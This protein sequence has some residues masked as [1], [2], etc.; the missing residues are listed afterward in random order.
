MIKKFNEFNKIDNLIN[1][2][3]LL[4]HRRFEPSD[5]MMLLYNI[6]SILDIDNF[7]FVSKIPLSEQANDITGVY[8]KCNDKY[9]DG[10]NTLS[11]E[12]INKKYNING[13][14]KDFLFFDNRD[15]FKSYLKY[16]NINISKD[17]KYIELNEILKKIIEN[18]L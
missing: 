8:Y 11:M 17:N 16:N 7:V 4:I 10:F 15:M 13:N 6:A 2:I 14:Y 9:F 3:Q 18:A 12:E 1:K 5:N